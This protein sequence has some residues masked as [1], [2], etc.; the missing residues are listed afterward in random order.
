MGKGRE[1]EYCRIEI[2]NGKGKDESDESRSKENK[3][4]KGYG[5]IPYCAQIH[6]L[7]GWPSG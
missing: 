7:P 6:S 1:Y 4:A 2:M 5:S 3:R